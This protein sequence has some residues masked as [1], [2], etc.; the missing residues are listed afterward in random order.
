MSKARREI[1]AIALG[2][3][4]LLSG[5]GTYS[6]HYFETTSVGDIPVE[7]EAG[8]PLSLMLELLE[9]D[10]VSLATPRSFSTEVDGLTLTQIPV[11]GEASAVT[12]YQDQET[13]TS[14]Q[15]SRFTDD[16]LAVAEWPVCHLPPGNHA[17]S[18]TI[19]VGLP[20]VDTHI[21]QH[22]DTLGFCPGEMAENPS[23]GVT[24]VV[25]SA[26][27][28][29]VVSRATYDENGEVVLLENGP[30][31]GTAS[32]AQLLT[33]REISSDIGEPCRCG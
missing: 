1:S 32:L 30:S 2:L 6:G 5:C 15:F 22:G 14:V 3:V 25:L 20:A 17:N 33:A 23:L 11:Q 26:G 9:A 31:A 7:V 13:V 27:L 4:L 21:E 28:D 12:I 19:Y 10:G 29:P 18:H 24:T 16:G 8:D